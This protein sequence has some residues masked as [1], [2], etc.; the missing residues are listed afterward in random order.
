MK[1]NLERAEPAALARWDAMQLTRRRREQRRG[2]KLYV[3]H[4]G[5]PYANGH[6][7]IGHALNKILKDFVVR[8]RGMAGFDAPYVPGWDCHG[9]PIELQV[10]RELGPKKRDLSTADFRRACRAYA[11]RFVDIQR[12]EFVRL[13]C[14]GDWANPYLT[15]EPKYQAAIVRALGAFVAATSSTKERSRFTGAS[16]AGPR[17]PRPKSNTSRTRHRPPTS[18]SS[19][20]THPPPSCRPA[21]LSSGTAPS[22]SSSGRRRR[23]QSRRIWRSPFTRSSSTALTLWTGSS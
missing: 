3:L 4:D 10:D 2:A 8:S 11:A 1:A 20:Q 6:I 22:R 7:H 16:T 5:P 15:M 18:S 9:L 12:D 17:W 23:G 13:L 14:S 21:S 19:W